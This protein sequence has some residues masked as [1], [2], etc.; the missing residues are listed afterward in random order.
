VLVL[1]VAGLLVVAG[2]I[3]GFVTPQRTTEL[4]RFGVGAVTAAALAAYFS[5]AGR[6]LAPGGAAASAPR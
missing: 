2:L 5:L 1:G 6:R 3:E 4:F